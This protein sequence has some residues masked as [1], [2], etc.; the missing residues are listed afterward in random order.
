M[1]GQILQVGQKIDFLKNDLEQAVKEALALPENK[2][3]KLRQY[4][5]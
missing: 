1:S 5:K 3:E 2:L 4:L